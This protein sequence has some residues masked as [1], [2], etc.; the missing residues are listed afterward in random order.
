[1][2]DYAQTEQRYGINKTQFFVEPLQAPVTSRSTIPAHFS[3]EESGRAGEGDQLRDRQVCDSQIGLNLN[4]HQFAPAVQI[5][6]YGAR[7]EPFEVADHADPY[8]FINVLLPGSIHTIPNNA[9]AC[10]NDPTFNKQMTDVAVLSGRK[11]YKACGNLDVRMMLECPSWAMRYS[12][13]VL[14]GLRK[15]DAG[16]NAGGQLIAGRPLGLLAGRRRPPGAQLVGTAIAV[17][18]ERMRVC[19]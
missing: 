5:D 15:I 13:K 7:S 9:I 14:S 4:V 6:K 1:M 12:Y 19:F 11:R 3:R 2:A 16:D 18:Q 10:F 17:F 8:D